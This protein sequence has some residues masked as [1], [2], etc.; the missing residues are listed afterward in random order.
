MAGPGSKVAVAVLG[1]GSFGTALAYKAAAG[2]HRVLLVCRTAA[3]ADFMNARR[4][5]PRVLTDVKY[6]LP[7]N[8]TAVHAAGAA[9]AEAEY[10]IHTI[11]VAASA[12]FFESS[13]HLLRPSLPIICAS[14]V[15]QLQLPCRAAGHPAARPHACVRVM[16]A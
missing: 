10:V 1:G 3:A 16:H 7:P 4:R 5:H 15:H 12:E 9:L 6:V 8:I 14:K 13:R 2:G 11:P